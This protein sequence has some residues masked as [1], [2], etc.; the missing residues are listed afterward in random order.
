MIDNDKTNNANPE[1][2]AKAAFN[3]IDRLQLFQPHEQVL[4]AA[5]LFVILTDAHKANPQDIITVTKNLMNEKQKL[6]AEFAAVRD[7]V[8][9]ELR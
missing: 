9:H 1:R 4:A 8:K 7:Y 3:V 5:A 6:R 2:V